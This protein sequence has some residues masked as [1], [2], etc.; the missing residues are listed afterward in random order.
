MKEFKSTDIILNI[1]YEEYVHIN[2]VLMSSLIYSYASGK[3]SHN[4][5][6]EVLQILRGEATE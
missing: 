5:F 1:I 3:L 4:E 2:S 6:I